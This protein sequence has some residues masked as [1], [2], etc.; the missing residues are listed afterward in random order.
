MRSDN[1]Y[2]RMSDEYGSHN[3]HSRY[4]NAYA[5]K[6]NPN[7]IES[8]D[9]N[10]VKPKIGE[11]ARVSDAIGAHYRDPNYRP[12]RGGVPLSNHAPM[13][14]II[15]NKVKEARAREAAARAEALEAETSASAASRPDP[16]GFPRRRPRELRQVLHQRVRVRGVLPRFARG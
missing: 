9:P 7:I 11:G 16:V 3:D 6:K 12:P 10:E 14:E 15:S 8:Y 13:P 2:A 4:P 5:H 1:H